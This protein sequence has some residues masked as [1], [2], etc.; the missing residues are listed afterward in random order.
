MK[1]YKIAID[2]LT[3]MYT[4][5]EKLDGFESEKTAKICM[6]LGQ[7]YELSEN[8]VEAIEYYKSSYSIWE[9]VVKDDDYEVIFTLATKLAELFEKNEAYRNAYE[10]LKSVHLIS[11]FSLK[12]NTG[13][14]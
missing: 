12:T 7:I 3:K 8:N 9:K 10:I 14:T 4:I 11:L 13:T 6:E 1:N 2:H 5:Y